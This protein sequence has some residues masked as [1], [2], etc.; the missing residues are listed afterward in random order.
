M[1]LQ[2][3]RLLLVSLKKNNLEA[4]ADPIGYAIKFDPNVAKMTPSEKV[5]N[6]GLTMSKKEAI[7]WGT[8]FMAA[9]THPGKTSHLQQQF[10]QIFGEYTAAAHYTKDMVM[11]QMKSQSSPKGQALL[12]LGKVTRAFANSNFNTAETQNFINEGIFDALDKNYEGPLSAHRGSIQHFPEVLKA[13][14]ITASGRV[15][16]MVFPKGTTEELKNAK[17]LKFTEQFDLLAKHFLENFDKPGW[18]SS[19]DVGFGEAEIIFP[20]AFIKSD[21]DN[22]NIDQFFNTVD[23]DEMLKFSGAF[24]AQSLKDI[25]SQQSVH[26]GLNDAG[27]GYNVFAGTARL[28]SKN[29]TPLTVQYQDIVDHGAKAWTIQS[30]RNDSSKNLQNKLMY[31]RPDSAEHRIVKFIDNTGLNPTFTSV[32]SQIADTIGDAK[33]SPVF[34]AILVGLANKETDYRHITKPNIFRAVGLFQVREMN[35]ARED[36]T[37]IHGNTRA[38]GKL[39][40]DTFMRLKPMYAKHENRSQIRYK[41][42]IAHTLLAYNGS[43]FVQEETVNKFASKIPID[44]KDGTTSIY[45]KTILGASNTPVSLIGK[46]RQMSQADY[47]KYNTKWTKKAQPLRAVR[48]ALGLSDYEFSKLLNKKVFSDTKFK[49]GV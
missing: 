29:G 5:S 18:G 38:A 41:D 10:H 11:S 6:F 15:R 1:D 4:A 34:K 45:A 39:F 40:A 35:A 47:E 49:K 22:V 48:E 16:N 14:G 27:T 42:I 33:M 7:D 12:E 20:K 25:E 19:R 8:R 17:L 31:L 44:P 21:D 28:N 24:D 30:D 2:P 32:S 43:S 3:E 13:I 9:S 23:K 37:N 46:P 26:I 36:L